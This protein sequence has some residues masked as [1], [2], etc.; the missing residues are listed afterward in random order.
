MSKHFLHCPSKACTFSK[1]VPYGHD[2]ESYC[3]SCSS[4]L[5]SDCPVCNVPL[6]NLERG[7]CSWCR[8]STLRDVETASGEAS[9]VG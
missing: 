9:G 4:K 7:Y 5:I 6:N 1:A 2:L 3:P 8:A